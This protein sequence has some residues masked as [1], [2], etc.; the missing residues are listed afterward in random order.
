MTDV[1][2]VQISSLYWKDNKT[3]NLMSSF[4]GQEPETT[5]RR[6]DHKKQEYK[7]INCPQVVHTYI[8]HM[9]GVNLL[10]NHIGRHRIKNE[11]Q[12]MVFSFI[13]PLNFI[14]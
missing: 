5:V 12:K 4:Y 7:E 3:V 2:S 8:K 9:G 14:S 1:D 13:L 11:I 10:E 6:F